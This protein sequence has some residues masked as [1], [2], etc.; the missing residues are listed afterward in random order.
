MKAGTIVQAVVL[1]L[2]L[3]SAA[4]CEVSKEYTRKLFKPAETKKT[5]S[6]YVRFLQKDTATAKVDIIEKENTE[7]DQEK[8]YSNILASTEEKVPVV[9]PKSNSVRTKRQRQ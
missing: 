4:S 5:D 7:K 6:V 9:I 8:N 3:A 1:M 2:L